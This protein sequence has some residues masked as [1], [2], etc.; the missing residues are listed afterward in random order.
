MEPNYRMPMPQ[1]ISE[2]GSTSGVGHAKAQIS[3]AGAEGTTERAHG[4]NWRHE[5]DA[6]TDKPTRTLPA[7][8]NGFAPDEVIS[9]H[10]PD[11]QC[12]QTAQPEIDLDIAAPPVPENTTEPPRSETSDPTPGDSDSR[13]QRSGRR[14]WLS[15][16]D[17]CGSS[18]RIS[19][20]LS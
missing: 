9:E 18:S 15:G 12:E 19:E 14:A 16:P 7:E 1:K 6:S 4:Q 20:Q 5:P 8:E 3:R 10:E 2:R 13:K 17:G 11:A